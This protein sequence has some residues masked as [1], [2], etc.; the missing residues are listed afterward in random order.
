MKTTIQNVIFLVVVGVAG[1]YGYQYFF[2][3][4]QQVSSPASIFNVYSLPERCR[5]EGE[6]LKLAFGR[7]ENGEI[8]KVGLNS[9]T[10]QFRRCLRL[11]NY[12]ASEID[13]AYEGIKNSL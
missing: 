8:K 4:A 7:Y 5:Q 2:G 10:A 3:S 13:E 11:A 6:N 12:S 9:Y 1:Y